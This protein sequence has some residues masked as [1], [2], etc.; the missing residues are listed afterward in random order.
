M[1]ISGMRKKRLKMG[2]RASGLFLIF[3]LIFLCAFFVTAVIRSRSYTRKVIVPA[4]KNRHYALGLE[5]IS[6]WQKEV[7]L[8]VEDPAFYRHKGVDL[9]TPGA[10]LTTI[11]QSLAKELYFE[12]FRSGLLHQILN[13]LYA[14]FAL[15]PYISKKDQ[16]LLFVNSVYLGR[17]ENGSVYGLEE[18]AQEYFEK[19]VSRLSRKEFASLAAM[20]IAP[21]TFHVLNHPEWNR[22]RT[23]RIL[24][25]AD[26]DYQP[27]GW[28]DLYYGKLPEEVIRYGLPPSSY[29][30]KVYR[31][32]SSGTE[33]TEQQ[34]F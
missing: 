21:S 14:R 26:G 18:A 3:I 6:L 23:L 17:S 5:E 10:G 4:L 11:T 13:T 31:G 27:R 29:S 28:R 20:I 7:L 34:V 9:R 1:N 22:E 24:K 12:R 16:L 8:K 25:L 32:D 33:I 19:P 30:S 15:H 2:L